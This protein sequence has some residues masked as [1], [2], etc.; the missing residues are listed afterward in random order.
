MTVNLDLY[1]MRS[2]VAGYEH[3]MSRTVTDVAKILLSQTVHGKVPTDE[4][5]Q[6]IGFR[7]STTFLRSQN[8]SRNSGLHRSAVTGQP[9]LGEGSVADDRLV[10]LGSA[11][12]IHELR[13]HQRD[14]FFVNRYVL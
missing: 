6:K 11:C 13:M 10:I 4:N 8:N 14:I 1:F 2:S 9:P 3:W 5:L 7:I 12:A